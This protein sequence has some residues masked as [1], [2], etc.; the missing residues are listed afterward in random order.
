MDMK[1]LA[2]ALG[3]ALVAAFTSSAALVVQAAAPVSTTPVRYRIEG[4]NFPVEGFRTSVVG[5]NN[6]GEVGLN[7]IPQDTHD[8][9]ES[10]PF[11]YSRGRFE[12]V[13]DRFWLLRGIGDNALAGTRHG[14][15]DGWIYRSGGLTRLGDTL[16][17]PAGTWIEAMS[18]AGQVTGYAGRAGTDVAFVSDGVNGRW[19]EIPGS[20]AA[21]GLAVNDHGDVAGLV[22]FNVDGSFNTQA[23]VHSGGQTALLPESIG[24]PTAMNNAGQVVTYSGFLYDQGVITP[25]ATNP[26][27]INHRGWILGATELI[28]DGSVTAI[29]DLLTPRDRAMWTSFSA[30]AINDRGQIVGSGQRNG[31]H[32]LFLATPVP[33]PAAIVLMLVGLGF[34]GL[35][36]K[37]HH[38]LTLLPR[39]MLV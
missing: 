32:L 4:F 11:I 19:V 16:A 10:Q 22:T 3:A 20:V 39:P 21:N 26:V 33:Q 23:F 15:G 1:R 35:V 5:L 24:V 6:R 2:S 31:A 13:G 12:N 34:V 29:G 9:D 27:D 7:V 18:S 36:T 28:H 17:P 25:L 30:V 14:S 37:R 8:L 38:G